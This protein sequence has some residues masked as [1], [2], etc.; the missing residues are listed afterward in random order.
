MKKGKETV[1]VSQLP[2]VTE[3]ISSLI[4]NFETTDKKLKI[5]ESFY[6]MPEKELKMISREEIILYAKEQKIYV[7]PAEGKKPAKGEPPIEHK[8]ITSQELAKAAKLLIEDNSVQY[9]KN[10]KDLLDNIEN[11]KKQKEES[12]AFWASQSEEAKKDPK[13]KPDKKALPKPEEIIIPEIK[14][15]D[16]DY[17]VV[18]YNYPLTSEE[19]IEMEKENIILNN[20]RI[21]KEVADYVPTEE[22]V[23]EENGDK[24]SGAKKPANAPKDTGKAVTDGQILKFFTEA[25]VINPEFTP[26]NI[27]NNLYKTKMTLNADSKL[28]NCLFDK[29][30]FAF[31][32]LDDAKKTYYNVYQEEFINSMRDL[33]EFLYLYKKWEEMHEFQDVGTPINDFSLE[34][35]KEFIKNNDFI[36]KDLEHNSVGNILIAYFKSRS[37]LEEEEKRINAERELE[38]QKKEE[39]EKRKKEIESQEEET[40]KKETEKKDTKKTSTGKKGSIKEAPSKPEEI[41]SSQMQ[42]SETGEK[43]LED[44]IDTQGVNDI[45]QLFDNFCDDIVKEF[46]NPPLDENFQMEN[47]SQK[48][49]EEM[50]NIKDNNKILEENSNMQ[51]GELHQSQEQEQEQE[52]DQEEEQD[53]LNGEEEEMNNNIPNMSNEIESQPL[54]ENMQKQAEEMPPQQQQNENDINKDKNEEKK[55][56]ENAEEVKEGE[57]IKDSTQKEQQQILPDTLNKNFQ[58]QNL[59]K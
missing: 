17:L 48:I 8:P 44:E 20:V 18:L 33:N 14:E 47:D 51:S 58:M 40:N 3:T 19:F 15:Y 22:K 53:E 7:D 2:S 28:R 54:S 45:N 32:V 5:I 24:K 30:E 12:I 41:P 26:E 11:L 38:K 42:G 9:R 57:G 4:F 35:I 21:I 27:Y 31:R 52:M 25:T 29:D 56:E 46:D 23:G 36:P 10:K 13:K 55:E 1:D 59:M 39:E 34:K 37:A 16:L 49:N 50:N 43:N 6:K